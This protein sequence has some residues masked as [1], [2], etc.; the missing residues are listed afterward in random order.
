MRV[1]RHNY[2]I[3]AT[4]RLQVLSED[5]IEAIYYASLGVLYETGV[6]VYATEGVD[7]ARAGGAIVEENT[8]QVEFELVFSDGSRANVNAEKSQ[9]GQVGLLALDPAAALTG[10]FTKTWVLWWGS[11]TIKRS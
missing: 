3:N 1:N 5:Q 11:S 4:P 8:A 10:D 6:R 7:V 9:S 2:E